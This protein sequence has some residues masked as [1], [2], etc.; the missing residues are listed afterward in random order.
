MSRGIIIF[1]ASGAGTTT[2]GKALAEKSSF[3]HFDLDDYFWMWD[4]DVPYTVP[5]PRAERIAMLHSAIADCTYFVMSGSMNDWEESFVPLFDMAV[6]VLTSTEIRIERLHR[7]EF[8]EFGDRILDGGDMYDNHRDFLDWAKSY[9]N[10][11]PP[12]RC[13]NVHEDWAKTLTCPV[14]RVD[15]AEDVGANVEFISEQLSLI[16]TTQI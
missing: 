6:F 10:G 13:L 12:Q 7:R 3:Q 16:S 9:D 5:R 2:I 11:L 8:L 1:G 4:T 15:G 14:L